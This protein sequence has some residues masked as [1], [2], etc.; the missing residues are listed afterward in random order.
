MR[1]ALT[2]LCLLMPLP[3]L[4]DVAEVVKGHILPGYDLLV[5]ESGALAEL[6]RETCETERLAPAFHA[7]F[8]AWMGVQHL[9]LGPAEDEG[10]S[11]AIVFWP[12]P[13]GLGRKAQLALLTGDPTKFAPDAF[14]DQ[15]VAARGLTGLERLLWP[16]APLP[17]DPCP[18]IR[19]T[20][21]D[22][23]RLATEI[24]DGWTN[25][26]AELLLTAGAAGN[27]AYLSPE[28]ARQALFT[29]VVTGLEHLRD[30]RLG[31]PLGTFDRPAPERAEARASGRSL[32]NVEL[33]LL[34]LRD[35]AAALSASSPKT[36][37]AL[38]RAVALAKGID[39]PALAGVAIPA[40]RLKVE[41]LQQSVEAARLAA[42]EELGP[43][44][45][46]GLG[47]NAQD[48]D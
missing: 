3:A 26:Y 40:G 34:A 15:S 42:V 14:A 37:A 29:L 11:L 20:A 4:A 17:A 16:E 7:A 35:M 41:V 27:T 19:A 25:G 48:G 10:R 12:D 13:K 5:A 21:S 31:R 1:A 39:D 30:Q 32:R 28:E 2:V 23:A 18:L 36:L 9:H 33:S 24:R 22:L 46:V 38:N 8:D 44:L 43:A 45:G 47:F 6:A